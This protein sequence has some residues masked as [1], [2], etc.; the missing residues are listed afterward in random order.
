MYRVVVRLV[1]IKGER[2]VE[3]DSMPVVRIAAPRCCYIPISA[4]P[5]SHVVRV[6]AGAGARISVEL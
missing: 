5:E 6:P 3:R 2:V 4:V 1:G